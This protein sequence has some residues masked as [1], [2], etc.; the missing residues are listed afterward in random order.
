MSKRTAF[1]ESSCKDK[2]NDF[3]HFIQLHKDNAQPFNVE[4][5]V[6]E[7]PRDQREALWGRLAVL[8]NDIILELPPKRWEEDLEGTS[9]ANAVNLRKHVMAVVDSVTLVASVSL[10]V[11]EDGDTYSALVE[12]AHIL[13]DVLVECPVSEA[14]LQRRILM[15]FVTWWKK[16]LKEKEKFGRIAFFMSLQKSLTLKKPGV[17]IQRLW[18]LHDV[19]LSLDY[20]SEDSKQIIDLLLQCYHHPVFISHDDGKR[21]LVFTFSWN[22]SFISVIHETI[23]KHLEFLSK[24]VTAH[25]A[26]IY[27]RAWNKASGD[28]LEQIENSCIQDLMQSAILLNRG[29]PVISKVRQILSSFH[30][31]K[32]SH[33]VDKMLYNLYTPIIWTA[34][35]V[36]NFQVRANATWLFT[37]AFPIHDPN[38]N[39]QSIEEDIQ[40]QLDTAMSLLKDPHPV[41]RVIAILGVCKILAKCWELFPPLV[42]TEF[43]KMLVTELA[44]DASS[45]DVRS[46]VFKC[47][48]IILDNALS[49]P[50]L[51]K[52]LPMAKNSLHDSSEKVRVAF[53]DMLIKVKEVRAAK[54]WE[55]CAMDHLLARL[56]IDCSSVSKRVASLLI[57]S[58]FP[59]NK[60]EREWCTRCISLTEMNPVAARKFY[61]YAHNHTTPTNIV[62][63]M[64]AL[65]RFLKKCVNTDC[66]LTDLNDSN[67]EN[68]AAQLVR[69]GKDTKVVSSLLEVVFILWKSV[70]ETLELASNNDSKMLVYAKF[71]NVMETF[72]QAFQDERSVFA[73]VQLVSLMPA[74]QVPGFSSTVLARLKGM[75]PRAVPKQY[76]QLLHCMCSWGRASDVV[77]VITDWLTE[78]APKKGKVKTKQKKRSKE[79][80]EAKP[81]L[82]LAYLDYLLNQTSTQEKVFALSERTLNQLLTALGNWNSVLYTH[83]TSNTEDSGCS[84]VETALKAFSYH[85]RLAVHLRHNFPDG[86]D[87]LLSLGHTASWVADTV[88]PCLSKHSSD[89]GVY[90]EKSEKLASQI[91]ESFLSMCRDFLLLGLGDRMFKVE[92]LHLCSCILL[93]DT[94]YQFIPA[95]LAVLKEVADSFVPDDDHE[96]QN[97]QEITTTAILERVASLF[98]DALQLLCRCLIKEPEKGKQLCQSAG[99]TLTD[100][101]QV[102]ARIDKAALSGVF[103]TVCAALIVEMERFLKKI[104]QPD[105]VRTPQ[106]VTDMPPVS[107]FMLS[108][109]I[110]S[111]SVIK[112]FLTELQSVLVSGN[113]T[114]LNELTA[115]VHILAVIKHVEKSKVLKSAAMSVL[116][117]LHKHAA[118]STD[119]TDFQ[120]AFY[121]SSVKTVKEI[122]A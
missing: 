54:F 53:L 32:D 5:V 90:S 52:L 84:S 72:F 6:Q 105:E 14:P 1:L 39:V 77:G 13:H 80:V 100:F 23:K 58:F 95:V 4:E 28:F 46:S 67:R 36:P 43:L 61:M 86:C 116:Q 26:E 15:L 27:F 79:M 82:A 45:S 104:T 68:S 106:S 37:E 91:T 73:L 65:R 70:E 111:P 35:R 25:F 17:E 98:D 57:N 10:N 112:A 94:G 113:I 2:L 33:S 87:Y 78:A 103:G 122:L 48:N 21:F 29:S 7:M 118:T 120:K 44:V 55:I 81:D 22:A 93:T 85:G 11:L 108:V 71:E 8:L 30:A 9:S 102:A 83:L 119:S 24:T 20:T 62:K 117:Q 50:L 69:S 16:G 75:D 63:L 47:L 18:S 40:K 12:I 74:H 42:I 3:L 110:K 59:V 89:A 19:L 97:D 109:I 114:S 96:A 49:H 64:L 76:D 31:K 51:E 38:Q 60:S 115:I 101:V 88:L 41:V 34:L 66:D 107:S 92:I 56:A 121:E 99:S